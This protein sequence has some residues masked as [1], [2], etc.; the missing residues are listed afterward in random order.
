[1][2]LSLVQIVWSTGLAFVPCEIGERITGAFFGVY[3]SLNEGLDWYL[4]P[5]ETQKMLILILI[6]AQAPVTVECFG[7][8]SCQ[9]D[10]FKRVCSEHTAIL[11][12]PI[13]FNVN[14]AFDVFF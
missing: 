2:A 13:P 8:I 7:S 3:D 11:F 4:F 5:I 10:I 14:F 1:M 6:N 9:R 12:V